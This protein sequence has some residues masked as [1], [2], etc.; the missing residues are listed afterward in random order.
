MDIACYVIRLYNNY[1]YGIT[2]LKLQKVLFYIQMY[3]LQTYGIPAF[4][5]DIE[6]WRLGGA[7]RDVYNYFRK[8]IGYNIDINDLQISSSIVNIDKTTK[9]TINTVVI[10]TLDYDVWKM[11]ELSQQRVWKDTYIKGM[12]CIITKSNIK[13]HGVLNI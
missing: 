9:H 11:V 6:A 3:H 10:K 8:Y 4:I 13:K 1:G 7:I 12:P 5:D 2:N